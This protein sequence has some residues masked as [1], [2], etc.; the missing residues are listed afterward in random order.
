MYVE[1]RK[2]MYGLP[3]AGLLSQIL[4]EERLKKYGYE[5]S[6]IILGFWKH[7]EIPICFTLVVDDFG[8]NYIGKEHARHLVS[9]LKEHYE[10]SEDW[11]GKKYVGFTF[12][13]DYEKK[14]V[15]VFMPGYVDHSLIR[16]KHGTQRRA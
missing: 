16:F 12:D 2:G 10:I 6:K 8:V 4:L 5:Q 11:E 15:H 1:V 14:M 3:H 9:V 7:K 13:W